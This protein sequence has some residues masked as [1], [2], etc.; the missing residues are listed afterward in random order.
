[1]SVVAVADDNPA[2][3]ADI[4]ADRRC[5][6][7]V[8]Q[9]VPDTAHRDPLLQLL[10]AEAGRRVADHNI[11]DHTRS[12]LAHCCSTRALAVGKRQ[13]LLVVQQQVLAAPP[14]LVV[15]DGSLYQLH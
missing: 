7:A 9:I 10:E 13:A 15:E 1:M 12:A 2:V 8:E 6:A 5:A 4:P 11:A 3:A 14:Q